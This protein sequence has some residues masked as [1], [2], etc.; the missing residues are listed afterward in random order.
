MRRRA[1]LLATLTLP[2]LLFGACGFL[3][4]KPNGER[5]FRRLCARCHGVRGHGNTPKYMSNAWAD[6]TDGRWQRGGNPV[7][8]EQTIRDGILGQMPAHDDLSREEMKVLV[9]YVVGLED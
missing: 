3:P 8:I 5:L 6:L 2:A 7:A 4:G 9:D 1:S